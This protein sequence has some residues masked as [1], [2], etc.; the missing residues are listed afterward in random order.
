MCV[1]VVW[2]HFCV[3]YTHVGLQVLSVDF[4]V[5]SV[6]DGSEGWEEQ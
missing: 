5:V 3:L 6:V 1:C 4:H 2:V